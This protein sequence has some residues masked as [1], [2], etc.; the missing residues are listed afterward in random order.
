MYPY[1]W[2]GVFPAPTVGG[3]GQRGRVGCEK[4]ME[5]Q[6][7]EG[8]KEG[9]WNIFYL[10]LLEYTELYPCQ[11]F[12]NIRKPGNLMNLSIFSEGSAYL[13]WEP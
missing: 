10:G 4:R 7:A 8:R 13:I 2:S 12:P 6:V 3:T 1:E 9:K 5:N 11:P